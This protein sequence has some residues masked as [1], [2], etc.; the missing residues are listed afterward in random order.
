[1][2]LMAWPGL[3]CVCVCV[4]LISRAQRSAG[5]LA[6]GGSEAKRRFRAEA[7]DTT[8]TLNKAKERRREE[9]LKRM[10]DFGRNQGERG[11]IS[12]YEE[13]GTQK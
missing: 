10:R 13:Q 5:R 11:G 3:V 4:C 1:M 7:G 2:W 6:E 8:Q 9:E 12:M